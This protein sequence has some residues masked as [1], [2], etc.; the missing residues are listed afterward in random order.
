MVEILPGGYN[1]NILRVNL[2]N[3]TASSEKV[4]EKFYRKYL[5]GAGFIAYYLYNELKR[6]TEPLDPENILIFSTGPVTGITLSGADRFSIGTKSP[7]TGGIALAE[8][9]GF[10][11]TEFKK[12][13]YDAL[14]VEGRSDKPVYLWINDGE[15]S[16]KD[17]S[18]LWGSDTKETQQRIR[19]ELGDQRVRLVQIGPAGENLVLYANIMSGLHDAAGRGGVGAVMGAK[20]LKAV[21]V[22]GQ[23][24]PKIA[25]PAGVKE[26]R[27]WLAENAPNLPIVKIFQ[28]YGVGYGVEGFMMSGNLPVRNFRDG[29]LDEVKNLDAATIKDTIRKGMRSCFACLVHCKKVVEFDKPYTHDSDYGGPEYETLASLGSNCGITNLKAVCKGNE[30]CNAYSVDTISMGAVIAFAMECFENGILTLEDTGG[31]ELRFGNHEAMLKIIEAVAKREGIGSLLADGVARAAQK[32]GKGAEKFALHV[33]KYEIPMHDPRLKPA[34]GLGYMINPHGADHCCNM[35]DLMYVNEAQMTNLN[36]VGFS[37]PFNV[38]EINP[39]KVALFRLEQLKRVLTDCM[40]TCMF[41]PWNYKQLAKMVADVTGW[42]T[43]VMGL[44]RIAERVLTLTRAFNLREGF[45]A[46]DD[47]LPQRFFQPKTDGVLSD[48]PCDPERME[49]SKRYYFALMGWDAEGKP[50]KEKLEELDLPVE[51]T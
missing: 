47:K 6:G 27:D 14:I 28:E 40:L 34:L 21:A 46:S 26:L 9:G 32:I 15:V 42:N 48:K 35:H 10:W 1:G 19:D 3:G 31:I 43:D 37:E 24:A 5:G 36:P 23:K 7:L 17:A 50:L 29:L 18:H 2:N 13:G 4:N 49:S 44:L 33:K 41:V 12:T 11:G 22:R 16:I 51:T 38:F 25:N 45:T 39:R 8:A 20:N 30:R